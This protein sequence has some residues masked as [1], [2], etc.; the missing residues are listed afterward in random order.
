MKRLLQICLLLICLVG[1]GKLYAQ[2]EITFYTT[3]GNIK[4][5]LTD[6]L[7]PVTVD[8]FKARVR[9]KFYDGLIFHRVIDG[10]VIQGGD[11]LGTGFGTPGYSTPDEPDT[12]TLKNVPGSIAMAN[13]G[14]GTN[15]CQFYFNLVNNT[16]LDGIYTVFGMVTTGFSVVQTIGHVPVDANKKPI[17]PVYIDSVRIT[18][19]AAAV[20]TIA[21]TVK[22][23]AIYPNPCRGTFTISL[24]V[25]TTNLDIL[26]TAGQIVYHT[27]ANGK[28]NVDL[29][30]Q[31]A[32]VYVVRINN[33]T[34]TAETKFIIQ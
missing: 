8:S 32:G 13:S 7:T 9:K 33:A 29:H 12:P 5:M 4:V 34:G 14:P 22:A 10:F 3:K 23:P 1:F 6:T 15:G 11:P 16:H 20:N 18:Q 28:L 2:T 17:T 21:N 25:I 24:P 19:S 26:N 31:P 30:N 27:T